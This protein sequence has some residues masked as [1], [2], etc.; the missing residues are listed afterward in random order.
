MMKATRL[1]VALAAVALS[2]WGTGWCLPDRARLERVLPEGG[3][4]PALRAALEKAWGQ[5]H[6][7]LGE[8]ILL[9]PE[10]WGYG[11]SRTAEVAAG[12]KVVPE[13]LVSPARS[14]Y[15]RSGH[16]DEP[17]IL[18]AAARLRPTLRGL[19]PRIYF[20]GGAYMYALAGWIA[21]GAALTPAR[22]VPGV[23]FYM[24]HPEQMAWLY[25][26]GRTFSGAC[27]LAVAWLLFRTGRRLFGEP[28]ALAAVA[29]WI[30]PPGIVIL[31][32]A[33]KPHLMGMFLT[34]AAYALCVETLRTG[35]TRWGQWAGAA[36]GLAMAA[37]SHLGMASMIVALTAV[38]RVA[39][40]RPWREEA[41]WVLR[42]AGL[43]IAAF[44]AATPYL[45]LEPK[46][47]ATALR[48]VGKLSHPCLENLWVFARS[49]LLHGLTWPVY[50]LFAAGLGW[51]A[52]QKDAAV[53]LALGSFC[54]MYLTEIILPHVLQMDSIRYLG[55]LPLGLLL[56]G[57]AA[58]RA[59]KGGLALA[60]A[61]ALFAAAHSA[62]LDYNLAL[63]RPGSSTRDR[64]GDWIEAHVP[65]GADIAI[66][67]LP[68]PSN[69]AYFR[70]NRYRLRIYEP[71]VFAALAASAPVPEWLVLVH[72]SYDD[73][74]AAGAAL[75]RY[76]T[77]A[78]FEPA[79]PRL[80]QSAVGD[81]YGNP[82]VEVYRRKT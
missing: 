70:W 67:R 41:G 25:L 77:A 49:G 78:R 35:E 40:G 14:F 52:R 61:A 34:L 36:A 30:A 20:Y 22:L 58:A 63:D 57:A 76:K 11:F 55:A 45:L 18:N 64:A 38:L 31:S 23:S 48:E 74:G 81:S 71:P 16:E 3:D 54:L 68:Q 5:L 73:H 51:A 43:F 46:T 15:L 4:T 9:N 32:H 29:L 28:A 12:W 19:N 79:G 39:E 66:L 62:V 6:A 33:M 80:L 69:S 1:L 82:V 7:R 53:R 42:A 56:G 60:G 72:P 10:S 47:T 27:Y 26:L 59:G 24:E 75:A 2:L 17:N 13:V 44:L 8:D 50:L 21:V 65:A 37:V